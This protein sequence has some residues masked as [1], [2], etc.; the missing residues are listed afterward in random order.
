M[1]GLI[2]IAILFIGLFTI[3]ATTDGVKAAFIVFGVSLLVFGYITIA[4]HLT[5]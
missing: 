4:V 3:I 5:N 1:I 2:M